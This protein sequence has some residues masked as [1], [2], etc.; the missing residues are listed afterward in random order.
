M[1]ALLLTAWL[2]VA[3]GGS[4]DGSALYSSELSTSAG[5]AIIVQSGPSGTKPIIRKTRRPGYSILQQNSGG[6]S[7]IVIQQQSGD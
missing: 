4:S 7:V 6:N 1:N 5:T 3:S 2:S